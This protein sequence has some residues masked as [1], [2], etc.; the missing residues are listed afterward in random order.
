MGILVKRRSQFTDITDSILKYSTWILGLQTEKTPLFWKK[1]AIC[2]KS[3]SVSRVLT[4]NDR[5]LR[6]FSSRAWWKSSF[7]PLERLSIVCCCIP[8]EAAHCSSSSHCSRETPQV[9]SITRLIER[10]GRVRRNLLDLWLRESEKGWCGLCCVWVTSSWEC[11]L[12]ASP[13]SALLIFLC[14]LVQ[15]ELMCFCPMEMSGKEA[16]W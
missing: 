13:C 7:S 2:S 15:G 9:I 10:V 11:L 5:S 4:Q 3:Y 1:N 8:R 12:G 6:T 14:L 16:V